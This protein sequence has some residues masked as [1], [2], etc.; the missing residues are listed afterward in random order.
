MASPFRVR[1]P[2][3]ATA[4]YTSS[5]SRVDGRGLLSQSKVPS[6][7]E[8]ALSELQA[9]VP[10]GAHSSTFFGSRPPPT[11]RLAFI[12]DLAMD[13]LLSL[14]RYHGRYDEH[15][16]DLNTARQLEIVLADS[17]GKIDVLLALDEHGLDVGES[18]DTPGAD[19]AVQRGYP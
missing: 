17:F 14:G 12:A 13:Y 5:Q 9:S 8:K 4:T 18:L 7:P 6:L 15:L 1:L 3:D 10:R 11:A 16:L 2:L 19:V